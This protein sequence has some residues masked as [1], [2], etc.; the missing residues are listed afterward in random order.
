[1]ITKEETIRGVFPRG[2]CS[3]DLAWQRQPRILLSNKK[4]NDVSCSNVDG[5][6][7]YHTERSESHRER[8]MPYDITWL[9]NLKLIY[10]TETH[11]DRES[12]LVVAK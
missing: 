1:M 2:G 5:P 10:E 6:R 11:T 8:Q 4:G 12:I 7:D 3:T 9:W